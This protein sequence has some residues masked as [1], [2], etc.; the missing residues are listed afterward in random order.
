MVRG[1]GSPRAILLASASLVVLLLQPAGAS[2]THRG[3]G[4][5]DEVTLEVGYRA[6]SLPGAP[7]QL[8]ARLLVDGSPLAGMDVE[9]W[10]E[11]DFLGPRRIVLGMRKTGADGTASVSIN[12]SESALRVGARFAASETYTAAEQTTEISPPRAAPPGSPVPIRD[13]GGANLALVSSVMPPLL[14]LTVLA[15]WLLLFGVTVATAVAIRRGRSPTATT[16][17]ETK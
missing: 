10:R 2:A 1:I 4:V 11:V 5:V 12:L 3:H 14:A 8:T 13:G 15:I 16:R 9:F 6:S 17:G 7:G